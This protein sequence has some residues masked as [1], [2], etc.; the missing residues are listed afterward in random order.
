[1]QLVRSQPKVHLPAASAARLNG[2]VEMELVLNY[3]RD[4]IDVNITAPM[5][6]MNSI[7]VCTCTCGVLVQLIAC[8]IRNWTVS[9]LNPVAGT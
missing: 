4:A 9:G 5:A 2:R 7:V 6:L 1:M 8:W 3:L